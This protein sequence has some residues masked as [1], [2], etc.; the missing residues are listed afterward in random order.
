MLVV[1]RDYGYVCEGYQANVALAQFILD[2]AAVLPG[3]PPWT[4]IT[5]VPLHP[6]VVEHFKLEWTRPGDT[7][8]YFQQPFTI[9]EYLRKLIAFE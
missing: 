4:P 8:L 1:W 5:Q 3:V 6:Q 2:G 9:T 7:H